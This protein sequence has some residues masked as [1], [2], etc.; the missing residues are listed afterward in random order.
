MAKIP[1]L[2]DHDPARLRKS[3]LDELPSLPQFGAL[4]SFLG[5]ISSPVVFDGI[6]G[7]REAIAL[8]L[9]VLAA[10]TVARVVARRIR[11]CIVAAERC[12]FIRPPDEALR[13]GEKLEHDH[14]T[15]ARLVAQIEFDHAS[16]WASP[17]VI[18][19]AVADAREL[20]RRFDIQR[21]IIACTTQPARHTRF[22][23]RLRDHR[24][25]RQRDSGAPAGRRLAVEFDD[26]HGVAALGVRSFSLPRCS[27]EVP[28]DVRRR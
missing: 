14:S 16:P 13:L 20:V 21:V 2:Y 3:T 22:D 6:L 15:N 9:V 19:H 26:V 23:A 28:L 10:V 17:T 18:D 27:P 5:L 11:G 24:G 1:G 7:P 25:T 12:L 8:C 4:L